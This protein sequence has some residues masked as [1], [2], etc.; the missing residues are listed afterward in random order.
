MI[1]QE[2][3]KSPE[4]WPHPDTGT[5]P[6]GWTGGHPPLWSSAIGRAFRALGDLEEQLG[7]LSITAKC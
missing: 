6:P 4:K 2:L 1:A 3:A 5:Q 7:Q